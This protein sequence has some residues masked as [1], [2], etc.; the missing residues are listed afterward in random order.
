MKTLSKKISK[1]PATALAAV[2]GL[3]LMANEASA[4]IVLATSN[5]NP[6]GANT[7]LN[8]DLTDT[9]VGFQ[10]VLPFNVPAPG[11]LVRVIFNAEASIAGGPNTWLDETI[12]IDNLPCR[13]TQNLDNAF[14]SGDGAATVND[15]WISA[16]SQCY[17][18]LQPGGHTV[19]VLMTPMNPANSQWWVDDMS[20]V[21]DTQ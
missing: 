3:G 12:F 15:A 1:I 16:A 20:L 18:R 14:V 19:R 4:T 9:L 21:I 6:Q 17:A 2:L 10:T 7:P 8:L 5:I 13:P 11:G